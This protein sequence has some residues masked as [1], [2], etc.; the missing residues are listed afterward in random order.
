MELGT[1]FEFRICVSFQNILLSYSSGY[2]FRIA[3][4]H[5]VQL[6][7][8]YHKVEPLPNVEILFKFMEMSVALIHTNWWLVNVRDV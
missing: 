6:V 2:R 5:L 1:M 4:A 7:C 3:N 8:I